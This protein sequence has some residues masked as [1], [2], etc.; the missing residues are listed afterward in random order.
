MT[1]ADRNPPAD[2][3]QP[4]GWR[5]E[6]HPDG[7]L[8]FIDSVGRRHANVDVVR[9]FPV[10]APAGPVA[11]VSATGDELAW[12]ESVAA[13]AEPLRALLDEELARREFLPVIERID[14]IVLGEPA[15]WSVVTDRGP[16]GFHVAHADDVVRDADGGAV[17]TDT[18]GLR[19]RIRDVSALDGHSRRLLD[20]TL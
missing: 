13:A 3:G 7:R 12:I 11:V 4:A 16:H 8:E 15:A 2:G 19:Y 1:T 18:V 5:L 9:G 14:S 20:R 17:V 6:R 10:T